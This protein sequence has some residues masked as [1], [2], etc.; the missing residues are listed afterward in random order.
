MD[1]STRLYQRLGQIPEDPN[2]PE[3]L[4]ELLVCAFG[5]FAR[6]YVLWKTRGGTFRQDSY[7]LPIALRDWLYSVDGTGRD[8]ATLQVVFG[9]GEE[10][11]ASDQ[12][13]KLEYK[14]PEAKRPDE[15]EEKLDKQTLRRSRTVR[16]SQSYVTSQ[17]TRVGSSAEDSQ[18]PILSPAKK[19]DGLP[20]SISGDEYE[21]KP[22][23]QD[24]RC[25]GKGFC[26]SVWALE[27]NPGHAC[28]A[29]KRE[30]GGPGRSITNDYINHL[31]VLQAA[32][33]HPPATP[34]S[35]PQCHELIQPTDEAW[36]LQRL[37]Q[38]P[39]GYSA[40]RALLSERIPR[41]PRI[42]SNKIV[43]L[44]CDGNAPLSDFVKSNLDDD[45]CL[46]RPYLGRRR[47]HR[48]E[49]STSRFQRFSLRNVPLHIDQMEALGL[50]IRAYVETM[51]DALALMHWGAQIDANDVEF[52][53]APPRGEPLSSSVFNCEYLG[54]HCMWILDFDC[55]RPLSMDDAGIEKACQAFFKNDPF[56]PRPES[57]EAADKE[58]WKVFKQRFLVTSRRILEDV[59]QDGRYLVE[60]LVDRIEEEGRLRRR[61]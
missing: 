48:Q 7:D 36:W 6:Y 31:R 47:R 39:P 50:D 18:S 44:F 10:Y 45:A 55:C 33:Q 37:H 23:A 24:Y 27:G 49:T 38:F 34:L 52:V 40:C 25:I 12:Y 54:I 9:R 56:Y 51:A 30:D 57:E 20:G 13:S 14:E 2:D 35:V 26:G 4:D 42:I 21:P 3:S 41:V 53:L 28:T 16:P 46:I 8:F 60:K 59:G 17:S 11:F 22:A 61:K 15:D 58:L 32:L 29:I 1:A 43:D 19:A 5:A